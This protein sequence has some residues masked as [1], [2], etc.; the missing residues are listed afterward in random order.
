MF[1]ATGAP[2]LPKKKIKPPPIVITSPIIKWDEFHNSIKLA[3]KGDCKIR[4][5]NKS[6]KI[7]VQEMETFKTLNNTLKGKMHFF[8]YTPADEKYNKMVLKAAPN[9]DTNN[10]CEQLKLQSIEPSECILLKSRNPEQLS[11]SYLVKFKKDININNVK[12][13]DSFDHLKIKWESYYK[14]KR[15]TQCHKCQQF[16]HGSQYCNQNPRCVKCT[17]F[18]LTKDCKIKRGEDKVQC[19]NCNGEH[20]ANYSGCPVYLEYIERLNVSKK[21]ASINSKPVEI[22][23]TKQFRQVSEGLSYAQI[24]KVNLNNS[25]NVQNSSSLYN[26]NQNGSK[27]DLNTLLSELNTLNQLCDIKKMINMV[28][29]LNLNLKDCTDNIQ[30][31]LIFQSICQK[32]NQ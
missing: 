4:Y 17:G 5:G 14:S 26:Q 31:L 27:D 15:V 29:E 1:F 10:I 7:Y 6:V 20:T 32:Y 19:A 18:H 16:G 11:S 8:S 25:Y 28:R 21:P 12:K 24:L 22:R 30:K 2:T 9:M 13:L 23:E 3:T